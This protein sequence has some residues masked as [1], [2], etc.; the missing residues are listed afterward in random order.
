VDFI[1]AITEAFNSL[2][3]NFNDR[4]RSPIGGAFFF[5]WLVFN[6]K[7]VYYFIV[8]VD[9]AENKIKHIQYS[10][11]DVSNLLVY[12]AIAAV[13]YIL[14]FPVISNVST[15]VWTVIDKWLKT[16]NAKIIENAVPLT[17]KDKV[18]LFD[19]MRAQ[20]KQHD[21]EKEKLQDQINALN[22]LV[23][24]MDPES[25]LEQKPI[26]NV[27]VNNSSE[28]EN[29]S[30]SDKDTKGE[31]SESEAKDKVKILDDNLANISVG[32]KISVEEAL[33]H[34]HV[35]PVLAKA[36]KET[37]ALKDAD[38]DKVITGFMKNQER[39]ESE[40]R[41]AEKIVKTQVDKVKTGINERKASENAAMAS[42]MKNQERIGAETKAA[43]TSA[44][45]HKETADAARKITEKAG[46]ANVMKA[47]EATRK[48]TEK[49]GLANVM[50]ANEATRKITEKAGLASVMKANEAMRKITD[51]PAGYS[52]DVAVN[53]PFKEFDFKVKLS[54][55]LKR[56]KFIRGDDAGKDPAFNFGREDVSDEI[57]KLLAQE[58]FDPETNT[59]ALE[60]LTVPYYSPSANKIVRA[61]W[62]LDDY[63]PFELSAADILK[64][65]FDKF[66]LKMKESEDSQAGKVPF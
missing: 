8:Q 3:Q 24:N 62:V 44:M 52:G 23:N 15:L 28:V 51:N 22:A 58:Y 32:N 9:T 63:K 18:A 4:I 19:L 65:W 27:S 47:T 6:W 66:N 53:E 42:V 10:F 2:A 33:R 41:A 16:Q 35:N 36:L 61:F 50:K 48:I 46:L 14:F 40:K 17:K 55:E 20:N 30:V 64:L 43:A 39:I 31:V 59:F 60:Y 25:T 37:E 5:S 29:S 34:T 13:V 7:F 45:K 56:D 26:I 12:P 11:I 1:K 49:I 57:L 38:D 54:N 21:E